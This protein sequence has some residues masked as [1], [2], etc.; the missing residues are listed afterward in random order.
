MLLYNSSIKIDIPEDYRDISFLL[1]GLDYQCMFTRDSST[2][3]FIIVDLMQ[4]LEEIDLHIED[5]LGMNDVE[6]CVVQSLEYTSPAFQEG[7]SMFVSRRKCVESP[8]I[9]EKGPAV[10]E[11]MFSHTKGMVTRS[12]GRSRSLNIFIGVAKYSMAD[13]VV[14]VFKEA[15]VT[16]EEKESLKRII[17][18]I[19]VLNPDLFTPTPKAV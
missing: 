1:V 8:K 9:V 15:S 13:I 5:I 17:Q 6:E 18:S 2:D 4:S 16:S 10:M 7:I 11:W 12:D 3:D 19:E 14:S